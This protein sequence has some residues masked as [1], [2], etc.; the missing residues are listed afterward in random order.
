MHLHVGAGWSSAPRQPGGKESATYFE[1]R[2]NDDNSEYVGTWH[3]PD[4]AGD[5]AT[6]ER[7]TYTR[8][9]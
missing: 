1:A 3:Y 8:M 7:I 6:E 5:D 4:G 9:Q 2:F